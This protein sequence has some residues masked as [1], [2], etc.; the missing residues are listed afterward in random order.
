MVAVRHEGDELWFFTQNDSRKVDELRR[1]PRMLLDYADP[2][3]SNYVSLVGRAEV[4]TDKA[5]AKKLWEEPL[6]TWFPDG[7]EDD[8]IALIRVDVESAE[9]WDAPSS[10]MVHAYGYVK[11]RL[12][13]EP[14]KPGDVAHVRM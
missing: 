3:A 4:R 12:T 13:G 1:D 7:P 8:H 9:Y 6:R 2:D 11:A 10:K 14:P 5:K